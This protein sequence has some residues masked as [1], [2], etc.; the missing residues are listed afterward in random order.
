MIVLDTNVV[1]ELMRAMP[2][3]TVRAWFAEQPASSV[4]VTTVTEAEILSGIAV[5]PDGRRKNGLIEATER[6]FAELF[7]GR[8]LAFDRGAACAYAKIFARR[9]ESGSPISQADCQI[10]ATAR[11]HGAAIA[12]RNVADFEG[13]EVEIINPWLTKVPT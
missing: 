13:A 11:S 9:R 10:A 5:L 2:H 7:A 8:I 1:S 4:F 6:I 12:T 3:Q